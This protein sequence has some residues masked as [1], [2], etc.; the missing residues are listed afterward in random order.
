MKDFTQL[1]DLAA[2]R[3]GGRV[4]EA[5]DEFFAS[6]EN[7]LKEANPVFIEGKYTSRGK[8][9]DGWESRRRRTP[10]HDWCIIRLGLPGK[11]HGITV[12]TSFFTGNY[13][14]RFS[15][16]GCDL[17]NRHPFAREK[18]RLQSQK[19]SWTQIFPETPLKGDSRNLFAVENPDRFTHLRLNIYPDGGVARL[20]I[21]G[22]A[23]PGPGLLACREINLVAVENGG[24]VIVSSDQFY[25]APRNLLM[26]YRA[27]NMGDGWETKR[28]RGPGHDWVILKLGVPGTIQRVEVETAHFKGNYPDSCALQVAFAKNSVIDPQNASSLTWEE[29]LPNTK[30]KANHRHVFANLQHPGVATHVRFQ[31]FPDGGI[32]RLRLFGRAHIP[33]DRTTSLERFN[34]LPR[35]RAMRALLDCCGSKKWA[36]QMAVSRPFSGEADLF[37]ASDKIWATLAHDDWLEAFLHHPPIGEKRAKARQSATASRWSAKE[38]SSAQ[39]AAP[40]VLQELAAQNRAYAEKFGYVFLICASGKS[41]DEILSALRK[42]LPNDSDTELRVAVE[43]LRKITRLRLEKLLE[44]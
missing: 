40:E 35:Q 30:L 6:K 2:E 10:G 43:E 23:V 9:M 41:S 44:S 19:T 21:H 22:D 26:P 5:N 20:R 24:S 12:D 18:S 31:I 27:K 34:R 15:L 28:R 29:L 14:E 11:I 7:L 25:G 8:W 33:T 1:A 32:S 13:P 38:Q 4:L 42:R 3:L 39:K 16:E 37:E 36:E 17:G